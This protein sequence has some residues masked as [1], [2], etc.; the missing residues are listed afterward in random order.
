VNYFDSVP[1]EVWREI[2][3]LESKEFGDQSHFFDSEVGV[4]GLKWI[5]NPGKFRKRRLHF[6]LSLAEH[7]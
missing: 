7:Q 2:I 4:E 5:P 6:I 1:L 3:Q